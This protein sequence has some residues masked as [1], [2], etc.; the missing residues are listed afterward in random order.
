MRVLLA[1]DRTDMLD[2]AASALRTYGFGVTGVRDDPPKSS[3]KPN[4]RHRTFGRRFAGTEGHRGLP[5][6]PQG[7]S[8][9]DHLG[10]GSRRYHIVHGLKAGFSIWLSVMQG[11]SCAPSAPSICS[12]S[13]RVAARFALKIH[14]SI[15]AANWVSNAAGQATSRHLR[16]STAR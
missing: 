4:S 3:G 10:N 16:K 11:G 13:M 5:A 9:A 1:E 7:V 15:S 2:V 8:N 6:D 12:R 14:I